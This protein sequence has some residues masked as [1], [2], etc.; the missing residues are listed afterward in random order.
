M[1]EDLCFRKTLIINSSFI[2]LLSVR[3]V[4]LQNTTSDSKASVLGEQKF[5]PKSVTF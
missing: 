5:K 3:I 4:I 2:V 1:L